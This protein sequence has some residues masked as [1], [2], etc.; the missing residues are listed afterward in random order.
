M[1]FVIVER[2]ETLVAGLAVRSPKRAL[3]KARDKDLEKTWSTLLAQNVDRPL[4]S[5]YVDH[6]PEINS[7]YTQIV[8]YECTSIDQVGRG[9]LVS[10]IPAGT[11]AKF[12]SV[13]TFPDLF[14]ALWG[15]IRDAEE[16][17]QIERSY[18]GDFEF[19]P[20][21]FGIDLYV[22]IVPPATMQGPQ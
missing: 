13:G 5:A 9:H 12:S 2:K 21:A 18:T 11:Y 17:R 7:Y 16:S 1:P 14:D 22:A 6:A 19:Y 4:A 15:Q 3:G 8:G 10:R 20:H